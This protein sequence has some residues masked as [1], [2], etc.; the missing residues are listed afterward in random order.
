MDA[1]KN[2]YRNSQS[3][4]FKRRDCA[5]NKSARGKGFE[6]PTNRSFGR[7][8]VLHC[9]PIDVIEINSLSVSDI[10]VDDLA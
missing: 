7:V 5:S 6:L 4:D 1:L 3:A 8:Q 10:N 2:V 9:A